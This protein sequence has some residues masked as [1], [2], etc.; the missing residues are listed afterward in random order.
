MALADETEHHPDGVPPPP[1]ARASLG[2]ARKPALPAMVESAAR[3]E[4]RGFPWRVETAALTPPAS[5]LGINAFCASPWLSQKWSRSACLAFMLVSDGSAEN[6]AIT[7]GR[8][9]LQV[10]GAATASPANAH[11]TVSVR[12]AGCARPRQRHC[13]RAAASEP[14]PSRVI[15]A[16][17]GVST[18]SGASRKVQSADSGRRHGR[19][20][21]EAGG[22]GDP[23]ATASE[24]TAPL[25]A[26]QRRR[27]T[28]ELQRDQ[29]ANGADQ[30][31]AEFA[32][33]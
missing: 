32:P 18:A 4:P 26:R 15:T 6:K 9:L 23:R 30:M 31:T 11:L 2:W 1:A 10:I 14:P 17:G 29:P 13:R 33:P 24:K 16:N 21:S 28:Q 19:S 7:P 25:T 22:G 27:I 3:L 5:R 8:G 20:R 12:G